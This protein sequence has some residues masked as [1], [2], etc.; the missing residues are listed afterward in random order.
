[1]A[2]ELVMP[3]LENYLR[4]FEQEEWGTNDWEEI[5]EKIRAE[6]EEERKKTLTGMPEE[7]ADWEGDD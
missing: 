5:Q 1:M 4:R 6:A 2:G 7:Q 3:G